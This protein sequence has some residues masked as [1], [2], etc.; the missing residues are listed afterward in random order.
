[1]AAK[2]LFIWR[3]RSGCSPALADGPAPLDRLAALTGIARPRVR[4]LADCPDQPWDHRAPWGPVSERAWCRRR[5]SA[6]GTGNLGP[7]S[8]FGT[9][10]AT[11]VDQSWKTASGPARTARPDPTGRTGADLFGRGRGAHGRASRRPS[12]PL[13][14]SPSIG[15]CSTSG[16]D[17]G[18][19]HCPPTRLPHAGGHAVRLADAAAL[20]AT[21]SPAIPA[22]S[23]HRW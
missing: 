12:R 3:T 18:L 1:M 7:F 5:S 17:R 21:T 14:T 19:A 23:G 9:I 2:H 11:A 15:A 6:A 22:S 4:I 8:D 20:A 13:T 16:R 10:S